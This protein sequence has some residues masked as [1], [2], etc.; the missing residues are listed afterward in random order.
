M[1]DHQLLENSGF[2]TT[3]EELK[4]W[5]T[6]QLKASHPGFQ[7]TYEELKHN[8]HSVMSNSIYCFQTTY[9]ELKLFIVID[10]KVVSIEASRLPM[11][12]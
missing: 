7:T 11:R 1:V 3:Y 9:E 4:Q 8:Q 12:N 2:Q 5:F 6:D 10:R